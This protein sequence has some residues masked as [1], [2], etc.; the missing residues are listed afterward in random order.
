MVDTTDAWITERTGIRSR[1]IAH[2]DQAASDLAV[3]AARKA[4]DAAQLTPQDLDVIICATGTGDHVMPSTACLIQAKLG[5][6]TV[7]AF[8]VAAA[9]S[10][11]I[12]A[13]SV[14]DAFVKAGSYRRVLVVGAEVLS[15][16]TDYADRGTSI[17][18]GDGAGAVV[19]GRAEPGEESV[20]LT[21]HFVADGSQADNLGI[22]AGGSRTPVSADTVEARSHY[23]RMNG[24]EVFRSAV[25]TMADCCGRVLAEAKYQ[26]SQVDWLIPHQA[27][28]R[29]IE[30][31][32]DRLKLPVE[33]VVLNIDR[34][35]N[36]SSA[37]IPVA[38][39]EAVRDGRI[40]RGQ[41]VLMTAFGAGITSGA[42]LL[43]Y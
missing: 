31:I 16:F 14:A 11:F 18:F 42:L 19:I 28:L 41:H 29:I 32:V 40:R 30:T 21:Q 37:S 8:D 20:I 13:L 22:V 34:T 10:G 6:P 3:E 38:F 2:P 9:C 36:T 33:R 17:L 27:N 23:L 39:D 5:A 4:L 24:R 25:R 1:H 43:R 15:R 7:M 26:V 35:G 12:Y